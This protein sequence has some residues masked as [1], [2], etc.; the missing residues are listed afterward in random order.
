MNSNNTIQTPHIDFETF[1][2]YS[3]YG[4]A[5]AVTRK[6]LGDD[7]KDLIN[8]TNVSLEKI[9][10]LLMDEELIKAALIEELEHCVSHSIV[11]FKPFLVDE[12]DLKKGNVDT[13]NPHTSSWVSSSQL[14]EDV[15][16]KR[17]QTAKVG[18]DYACYVMVNDKTD[19][20]RE[21][22]CILE[23]LKNTKNSIFSTEIG[24]VKISKD[25]SSTGRYSFVLKASSF[26]FVQKTSIG[27]E[28]ESD[29]KST[30]FEIACGMITTLT[31]YK[32]AVFYKP[33]KSKSWSHYCVIPDMNLNMLC[34]FV[35]IFIEMCNG[36]LIDS[37]DSMELKYVIKKSSEKEKGQ[38]VLIRA[39]ITKR[40]FNPALQINNHTLAVN[41]YVTLQSVIS[42]TKE[43][44][45]FS[46]EELTHFYDEM[47]HEL[48]HS[49]LYVIPANGVG[50]KVSKINDTLISV[51]DRNKKFGKLVEQLSSTERIFSLEKK[52][53]PTGEKVILYSTEDEYKGQYQM[54]LSHLLEQFDWWSFKRFLS[55]KAS[56]PTLFN[57]LLKEMALMK[58]GTILKDLPE[59]GL[60]SFPNDIAEATIDSFTA[61]GGWMHKS[62]ATPKGTKMERRKMA[63]KKVERLLNIE[64]IIR[65]AKTSQ[66]LF[67]NAFSTVTRMRNW[68]VPSEGSLAMKLINL[69]KIPLEEAKSLLLGYMWLTPEW[70]EAEKNVTAEDD[71]DGGLPDTALLETDSES[72]G[73]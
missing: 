36:F 11:D 20:I 15:A 31:A 55:V 37:K 52:Q 3:L 45:G 68:P 54:L 35:S 8:P 18:R 26:P 32:P 38:A 59:E 53:P 46:N 17:R 65:N 57:I 56:Y 2:P 10:N 12:K 66:D 48:G 29:A 23:A 69:G 5:V 25:L 72:E 16:N 60:R 40:N 63:Q 62:S 58:F 70:T 47:L 24:S 42:D 71:V 67:N 4:L 9:E 49:L 19:P 51:F 30:L 33:Y 14:R 34:R 22:L 21:A 61:I 6:I 27:G 7:S 13:A 41:V 50:F 28:V 73:E 43:R 39:G 1:H 44:S 64:S